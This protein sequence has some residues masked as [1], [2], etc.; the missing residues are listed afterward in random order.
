MLVRVG[1]QLYQ[2][3]QPPSR[4]E[5]ALVA[6]FDEVTVAS[7]QA[8]LV[9]GDLP[10]GLVQAACLTQGWQVVESLAENKRV[11]LIIAYP[12]GR[13]GEGQQEEL[14]RQARQW[15]I[16]GGQML[17]ALGS[18]HGWAGAKGLL[19]K[20]GKWEV[21]VN[22]TM[23]LEEIDRGQLKKWRETLEDEPRIYR[24][25]RFDGLPEEPRGY[26]QVVRIVAVQAK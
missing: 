8:A 24:R 12:N 19:N 25:D 22:L 2:A 4:A 26:D 20:L 21:L 16:P 13:D 3:T 23:P 17:L 9:S 1:T 11:S 6:H 18:K 14:L 7:G 5:E 10:S 15:L